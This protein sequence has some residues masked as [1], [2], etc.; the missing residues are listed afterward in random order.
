MVRLYAPAMGEA[1]AVPALAALLFANPP[2]QDGRNLNLRTA[3]MGA[4]EIALL[5]NL[6]PVY[7]D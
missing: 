2:V 5:F 7:S 1:G 3:V 6:F 4:E